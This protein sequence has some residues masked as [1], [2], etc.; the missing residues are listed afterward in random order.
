MWLRDVVMSFYCSTHVKTIN[1][2]HPHTIV[3][4]YNYKAKHWEKNKKVSTSKNLVIYF[5]FD[6]TLTS[7]ASLCG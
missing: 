6:H 5:D 2:I 1:E 4:T 7:P 3:F